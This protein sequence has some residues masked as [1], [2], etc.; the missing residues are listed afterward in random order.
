MNDLWHRIYEATL[1]HGINNN[2]RREVLIDNAKWIADAA[3]AEAEKHPAPPST[4]A[5]DPDPSTHDV[6][7]QFSSAVW[8]AFAHRLDDKIINDRPRVNCTTLWPA[9]LARIDGVIQEQ[10]EMRY[11]VCLPSGLSA[12]WVITRAKP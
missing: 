8:G 11:F 1:L 10:G 12:E 3:V 2:H 6:L 7:A 5:P 9:D 4:T